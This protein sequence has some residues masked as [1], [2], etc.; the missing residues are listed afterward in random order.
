MFDGTVDVAKIMREIKSTIVPDHY[1]LTDYS[2]ELA[3]QM[4][5]F[6]A[7]LE[8]I[9]SF[10]SNTSSMLE[11]IP[12]GENLPGYNRFI[13]PIRPV[14]RM[15]SKVM[16]K[17]IM[18]AIRDQQEVNRQLCDVNKALLERQNIILERQNCIMRKI[19]ECSKT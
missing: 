17:S 9:S 13:W 4:K 19:D 2:G 8:R 10:I 15:I 16:R 14:F 12:V 18:F 11:R 1:A 5:A 6:D 7:E 3:G